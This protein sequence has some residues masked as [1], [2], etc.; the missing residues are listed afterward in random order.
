[1]TDSGPN[2]NNG[3]ISIDRKT[4]RSKGSDLIGSHEYAHSMDTIKKANEKRANIIQNAFKKIR[5]SKF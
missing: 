5:K 3:R 2:S 1:M 4:V